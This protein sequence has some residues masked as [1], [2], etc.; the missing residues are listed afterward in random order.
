MT[1]VIIDK[2]SGVYWDG[3]GKY[4]GQY[5][6]AWKAL[7]PAQGEAEDG[8]PEALRAISRIGYDYY[9]NGFCNLWRSSEA[10]DEDGYSY[11]EYEMDPY[12]RDMVDYLAY[13]I[14]RN[15]HGE[16]KDFLVDA[17]GYGNWSNQ[18]GI[19]DRIISHIM[20]QIIEQKLIETETVTS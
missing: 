10:Y 8:W 6:R 13:Q 1:K 15:M 4:Q 17:A 3:E 9:N 18:A 11:D 19:I 20:E 7:I 2:P 5:D 12:Y 16:L 14:P